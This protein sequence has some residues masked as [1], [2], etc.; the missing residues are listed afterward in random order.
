MNTRL[1]AFLNHPVTLT[2]TA[3]VVR[4]LAVE[5]IS[6]PVLT[7][8]VGVLCRYLEGKAARRGSALDR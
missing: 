4:M 5:L 8:V 6:N 7:V 1:V 2:L 3:I